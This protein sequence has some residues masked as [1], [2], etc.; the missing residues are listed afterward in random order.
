MIA[1]GFYAP[2]IASNFLDYNDTEYFNVAG[3][4]IGDPVIGDYNVEQTIPAVDFV[5]YWAPQ[6]PFNDTFMAY[7]KN[8]SAACGYDAYMEQYLVFPPSGPQPLV[9][10][11]PTFA[12]GSYNPDCDTWD[13]IFNAILMINPGWSEYLV[14]SVPPVPYD[15]LGFPTA[16]FYSPPGTQPYFNRTDVKQAIHAPL[17]VNWEIC[18][19][20]NVYV[21]GSDNSDYTMIHAIPNVINKTNNVIISHGQNDFILLDSGTLM[22]IQNMSWNGAMGFSCVPDSPLFVPIHDQDDNYN[23]LVGDSVETLAAFG[24]TGTYH[25]ERGLTFAHITLSGHQI[26]TF[27]PATAYREIEFLLGRVDS[28]SSNVPLSNYP[29]Y[30]QPDPSTFGKGVARPLG[31]GV[32]CSDVANKK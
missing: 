5:E 22:N 20:G 4:S 11:G 13:N 30:T 31:K 32:S 23:N 27:Q 14:S 16:L 9:T 3:L 1:S 7:L 26:P 28:L 21:N 25:T 6:F 15:V 29:N 17:D 18:S 24:I 19:S 2:Y 12:N 10:P 8:N